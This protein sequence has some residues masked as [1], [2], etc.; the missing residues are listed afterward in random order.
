MGPG[1]P[2]C[3]VQLK[4]VGGQRRRNSDWR[5]E[6]KLRKSVTNS[7][8]GGP[9]PKDGRKWAQLL[10]LETETCDAGK[11]SMGLPIGCLP[12]ANVAHA[13]DYKCL[14]YDR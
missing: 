10:R 9:K 11:G 13:D 14:S 12:A 8:H 7:G 5:K 4:N 3:E 2:T 6:Q 1:S